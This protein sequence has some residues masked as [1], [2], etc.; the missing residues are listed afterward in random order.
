MLKTLNQV[1]NLKDPLKQF[2]STWQF[3][4]PAGSPLISMIDTQDLELRCTTYGLP[5]LNGD[6]TEVTWGGFKRVYAGK[7]TR[8]GSWSVTFIEV[9]DASV[10]EAFK[11]WVNVYHNY[12][13]G[14]ISLLDAYTATVNISLVNPDVYDPQPEGITRYDI[15]LFDVFPSEVSMPEISAS[16]SADVEIKVNFNFNYFLLGDEIEGQ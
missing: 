4:F 3:A 12:K 1:R 7:Q 5:T 8:Q 13:N 2:V 14:T 6:T 15:R 10:V 16:E 11:K 9:W